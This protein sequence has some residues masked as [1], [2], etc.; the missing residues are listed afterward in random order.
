[1][2]NEEGLLSI[3]FRTTYDHAVNCLG[4]KANQSV[5]FDITGLDT[6]EKLKS[7]SQGEY[8]VLWWLLDSEYCPFLRQIRNEK[9]KFTNRYYCELHGFDTKPE[10]CRNY[11]QNKEHAKDFP[12][13]MYFED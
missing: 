8:S 3:R 13:C 6:L 5:I 2:W 11:P 12:Y 7:G 4:I 1:M 9:G 10:I